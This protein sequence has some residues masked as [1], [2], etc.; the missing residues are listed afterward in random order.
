MA[1]G[2]R[3]G[4]GLIDDGC[5]GIDENDVASFETTHSA[6]S[7]LG[8]RSAEPFDPDFDPEFSRCLE[9]RVEQTP[10]LHVSQGTLIWPDPAGPLRLFDPGP[11]ARPK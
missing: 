8:E 3:H 4:S 2:L 10:R 5:R 1:Q 6:G 11:L 7:V 9:E